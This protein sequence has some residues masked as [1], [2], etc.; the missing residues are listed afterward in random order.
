MM[1]YCAKVTNYTK[2]KDFHH[3]FSVRLG[4]I[5]HLP[6]PERALLRIRLIAEEFAELVEA[7]QKQD[8]VGTAKECADLLYVVYGTAAEYGFPIDA[9]FDEVH[10]SNMTK[11]PAKDAGGKIQKGPDYVPPDIE[12]VLNM[13]IHNGR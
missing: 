12:A 7:M 4:N 6:T 13:E 5:G 1:R 3:K 8:Y 10:H 11:T 9:V 2:V